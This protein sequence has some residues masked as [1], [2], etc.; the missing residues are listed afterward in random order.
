MANVAVRQ[1]LPVW[2]TAYTMAREPM[3]H[4]TKIEPSFAG[5]HPPGHPGFIRTT[6]DM[7]LDR[8]RHAMLDNGD[9]DG[10]AVWKRVIKAVGELLSK[11]RPDGA[12]VQ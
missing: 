8:V 11:E 7:P 2:S 1:T 6:I 10:Y 5:K 9:L 12:T 3:E 4:I